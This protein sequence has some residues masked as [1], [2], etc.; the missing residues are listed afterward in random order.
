M[1]LVKQLFGSRPV[2]ACISDRDTVLQIGR[3]AQRLVALV[4]VAFQHEADY[5]LVADGA[6]ANSIT[7]H[8]RLSVVIL[9]AISVRAVDNN[10]WSKA[11]T[12]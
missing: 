5:A 4:E 7:E 3:I 1:C 12:L 10:V 2:D 9:V 6:L 8:D 11:N